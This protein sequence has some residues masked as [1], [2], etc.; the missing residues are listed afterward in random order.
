MLVAIVKR[1][2]MYIHEIS[3]DIKTKEN[4]DKLVEEFGLLI[5]YYFGNGQ[6]QGRTESQYINDNKMV[7]LPFTLEK[8]SLN[9]K[10]NNFYVNRQIKKIEELCK[11]TLQYRTVG[12]SSDSYKTPCKCKKSNFYILI[13]NYISIE[14]PITCG[15]CNKSVPLYK[16]PIYYDYGYQP[17]LNWEKN[18]ICCDSL[19]MNGE[20]GERWALNQ[21]QEL[22]S[23]LSKQ[24]LEICR[25]IERLTTV[26]TY[27]YLHNYDKYKDDKLS[28]PCP[29]CNNRWNL[30]EQLYKLYDFKCDKCK[31]VS[32]LSQE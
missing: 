14:S 3:I 30:K 24:G 26:P 29:N 5:S 11:S 6:T 31:L 10:F 1:N 9:K 7:C 17:I 27:Y 19:Q 20:V 32:T 25:K 18:Y 22:K 16:L 21:M 23:P 13:T 15:T 12:K 8:N 28:R 2:Q 4:K